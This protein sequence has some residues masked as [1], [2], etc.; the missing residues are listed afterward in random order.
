[1]LFD[2]QT[3]IALWRAFFLGVG[4]TLVTNDFK[5]TNQTLK[6]SLDK[7]LVVANGEETI[8]DPNADAVFFG[9]RDEGMPARVHNAFRADREL[10][11]E[12]GEGFERL[13]GKGD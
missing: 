4:V 13:V 7:L 10:A 12:I 8:Y 2:D 1:M 5:L 3:K 11:Q 6:N 9:A